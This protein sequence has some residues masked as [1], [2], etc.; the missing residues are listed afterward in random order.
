MKYIRLILF[1]LILG[2]LTLSGV[3]P[4]DISRTIKSQEQALINKLKVKLIHENLFN[5]GKKLNIKAIPAFSIK[6]IPLTNQ[7]KDDDLEL[8]K[9]LNFFII[10]HDSTTSYLDNYFFDQ[11]D[12]DIKYKLENQSPLANAIN[13]AVRKSDSVFLLYSRD[14]PI[15]GYME[16][17]KFKFMDM[18]LKMYESLDSFVK[19]RFGSAENYYNEIKRRRFEDQY[20]EKVKTFEDAELIYKN[21]KFNYF[22]Y[23]IY[24]TTA[25]A[26]AVIFEVEE[27]QKI[28]DYQRMELKKGLMKKIRVHG[29]GKK[30]I[31]K[32]SLIDLVSYSDTFGA[33]IQNELQK[34]LLFDQYWIFMSNE[35]LARKLN[36]KAEELIYE[37]Y[38]NGL[39][40]INDSIVRKLV[41]KEVFN[42]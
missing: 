11:H 10:E 2:F 14:A 26:N 23:H 35:L 28:T 15:V 39:K 31:A 3:N 42:Q 9:A 36:D 20:L 34:V 4:N 38:G 17:G 33:I 7:M 25:L 5:S 32:L 37:H 18:N 6:V 21:N 27:F 22:S 16:K 30:D 41:R 8:E 19:F 24:D 1:F 12:V 13:F 40:S 29:L